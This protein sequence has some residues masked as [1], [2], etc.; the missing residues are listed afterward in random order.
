MT[1]EDQR[2]IQWFWS[3]N[4]SAAMLSAFRPRR[5]HQ[6]GRYRSEALANMREVIARY[7]EDCRDAGDRPKRQGFRRDRSRVGGGT[8]HPLSLRAASPRRSRTGGRRVSLPAGRPHDPATRGYLCTGR[9]A[10]SRAKPPWHAS[11]GDRVGRMQSANLARNNDAVCRAS[12]VGKRGRLTITL[13][14]PREQDGGSRPPY[15]A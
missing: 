9:R 2:G 5:V 8:P 1:W 10:R 15:P 7:L 12:G 4:R 11:T 13:R 6:R 3:R 14:H